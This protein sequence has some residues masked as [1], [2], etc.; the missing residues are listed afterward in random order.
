MEKFAHKLILAPPLHCLGPGPLN[1][2]T[3]PLY[4]FIWKVSGDQLY[5][6]MAH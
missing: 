2:P 1:F 4:I 5:M 6:Y 3:I